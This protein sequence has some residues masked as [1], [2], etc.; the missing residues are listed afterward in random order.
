MIRRKERNFGQVI[1]DRRRQLDLTQQE[2]A[3]R[4][5]VS[6]PY[7]GHLESSKRHPSDK[8]L[9][10]L[11]GVLGLDRRELFMLANPQAMKLLQPKETD[12]KK[13]AWDEFRKDGQIRRAHQIT[14]DEMELLSSVALMGEI[15]SPRDFIYILNT[16]RQVLQR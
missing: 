14:S 12:K 7:V 6:T 16:V 8:V 10:Q 4:I 13:L 9:G 1:R 11:A 15:S 2:I 3:R 5:K